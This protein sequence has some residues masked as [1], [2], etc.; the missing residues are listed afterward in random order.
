MKIYI[1]GGAGIEKPVD[2]FGNEIKKGDILTNNVVGTAYEKEGDRE[3]P[4]FV[5]L[6]KVTVKN[7]FLFGLGVHK[8]R[9]LHDG[10]FYAHDFTFR[11]TIKLGNINEMKEVF[12]PISDYEVSR[13]RFKGSNVYPALYDFVK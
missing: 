5:V 10:R 4:F 6:K 1:N 8:P 11:K 13:F 12:Q 2:F 3:K 9:R 7:T